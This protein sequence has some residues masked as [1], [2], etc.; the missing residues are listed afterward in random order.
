MK[1]TTI[2]IR[3]HTEAGLSDEELTAGKNKV[4]KLNGDENAIIKDTNMEHDS[5]II[6]ENQ[7]SQSTTPNPPQSSSTL[8]VTNETLDTTKTELYKPSDRGPFSVIVEKDPIDV[9]KLGIALKRIPK[10]QIITITRLT[11]KKA[12]VQT[13]SY[14]AANKLITQK[15]FYGIADY[16]VY[17]PVNFVTTTGIIRHIPVYHT[18]KEIW[19][20]LTSNTP[21]IGIERL[22]IWDNT[23]K[24]TKPSQSIKIFFRSTTIPEKVY[25][26]YN[27][28]RVE[29]YIQLPLLCKTCLE[30]GHTPKYCKTKKPPKCGNCAETIHD[31]NSICET[32]CAHCPNSNVTTAT[33]H[34]TSSKECPTYIYQLE[35][36]RI[37]TIKRLSLNEA[38]MEYQKLNPSVSKQSFQPF[39]YSQIV[40]NPGPS[41][42]NPVTQQPMNITTQTKT[43]NTTTKNITESIQQIKDITVEKDKHLQFILNLINMFQSSNTN[44]THNELIFKKIGDSLNEYTM[45]NALFT[46]SGNLNDDDETEALKLF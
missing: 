22:K 35:L 31:R 13:G 5:T 41:N 29:H 28:I 45:K 16:K 17:L 30:Y 19:E 38:K 6:M 10:S 25:I 33:K 1:E 39:T 18:E 36:K 3:K 44:G 26:A 43:D 40:S 42:T 9:I 8:P 14:S 2:K 24:T 37:M 46:L 12:R 21:I 11:N 27:P 32:K 34:R 23:N 7:H 4:L 15:H 20:N